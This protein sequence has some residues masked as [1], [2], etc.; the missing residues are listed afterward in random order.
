MTAKVTEISGINK[1]KILIFQ[2]FRAKSKP[3]GRR[4]LN[5]LVEFVQ[6]LRYNPC[7]R[8]K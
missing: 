8:G 6:R 7:I 3:A 5:L 4:S 1:A 2:G